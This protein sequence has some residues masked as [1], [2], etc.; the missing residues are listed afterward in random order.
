MSPGQSIDHLR[1]T[2][3][4]ASWCA[5]RNDSLLCSF[6]PRWEV[7]AE[8]AIPC[9]QCLSGCLPQ[10]VKPCCQ[11]AAGSLWVV[12]TF[13]LTASRKHCLYQ[14]LAAPLAAADPLFISADCFGLWFGLPF[15]VFLF[16]WGGGIGREAKY[17]MDL[18]EAILGLVSWVQ[19]PPV[20]R[21]DL[22]RTICLLF[23]AI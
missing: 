8:R 21:A 13:D 15:S 6:F 5:P 16:F 9:N 7:L 23:P 4:P 12:T 19:Q 1:W 14:L 22:I 10:C 17:H 18:Q 3:Q 2:G 20:V 11:R